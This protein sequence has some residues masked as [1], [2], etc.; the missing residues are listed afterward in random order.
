MA[1]TFQAGGLA[2]GLDTNTIVDK[3]VQIQSR[4]LDLLR[5]RQGALRTQVSLLADLLSKLSAL[6]DAARSLADGGVLGL[7]PT[8]ANV[9]FTAAPG[10]NAVAG[11]YAV[12][13][14]ALAQAAKA[15]SQ[16]FAAGEV[17]QG[18]TLSL[19]VQGTAYAVAVADGSA[20]EDVAAA[21]RLSGA[22]VSAVVLD[23]GTSRYLSITARDTGHPLAGAP[24]DALTIAEATTGATG[25]PLAAAVF[26]QA[27]NATVLVDGLT[28]VRQGNSVSDAV[29]GTTLSLRTQG[30]AAE[31]LVLANDPDGTRA[32][33]Q[34]FVD[35]YNAVISLVQKQLGVKPETDRESTLAG[36]PSLRS[37]Q[38]A[39]QQIGA[40]TVPGLPTVRAL[41]DLGVRTQRDG[42][43]AID[44]TTLSRAIATDAAAVNAVFATAT[45]GI[46]ALVGTLADGFT[47]AGDGILSARRDSLNRTVSSMDVQAEALQ[48]RLDRYRETLVAQFAA[49]ERVVSGL[50][51]SGNYLAQSSSLQSSQER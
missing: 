49:M 26:Q 8:S 32:K 45:T 22:P 48:K 31:D 28:F 39:L 20:L 2:S 10:S 29:P 46:S 5:K 11:S 40:A 7:K 3:L 17:V 41:A 35:A 51:A 47:R 16:A 44:G 27:R 6:R 4:P 34:T 43:L 42:T 25:R 18:G 23:D 33:L 30:G 1:A 12:Q 19:T 36:D 13:V 24:A 21:I 50:R 37:L 15:R 14:T 38:S 9:S